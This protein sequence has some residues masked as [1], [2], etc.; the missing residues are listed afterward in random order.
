[1][2][3]LASDLDQLLTSRPGPVVSILMPTHR[4]GPEI[5]QDAIRLKNLLREADHRLAGHALPAVD[6]ER[7]L[8]AAAALVSD[9]DF[10]RHQQ[11]G[12]AVFAAPGFFRH[13]RVSGSLPESVSVGARFHV[14]PLLPA[15][16]SGARFYVL[17]LSQSD[18]RLIDTTRDTARDV[19]LGDMPRSLDAALQYDTPDQQLQQHVGT[20]IGGERGAI[21]HGHGAGLDH[22]KDDI[23]QFFHRVDAGI[24][25]VL[26]D[27]RAPMVLAAV[28]YLLPLYREANSHP[29]LLRESVPGNPDGV[30]SDTLRQRAW[31][32]VRPHLEERWR[33]AAARHASLAGTGRTAE[34]VTTVLPAA[35]QGRVDQLFVSVEAEDWGVFDPETGI[36]RLDAAPHPDSEELLNLAVI[37][38]M[39]RGGTVHGVGRGQVP[40]G[41]VI[42]AILRY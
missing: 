20:A 23:L 29:G 42:A 26:P 17:A 11:D 6:R 8:D 40:A 5:R 32:L 39:K 4:A 37:Y 7:L 36:V 13:Y 10:W 27:R 28:D 35:Y 22:R 30:S 21:F 24:K 9:H 33:D 25:R 2:T 41:G 34:D 12:L 18:V 3:E 19:A 14:K 15:L 31:E 38:A 16:S 1:L